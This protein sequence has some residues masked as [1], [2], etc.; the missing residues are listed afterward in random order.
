MRSCSRIATARFFGA[1]KKRHGL[2]LVELL[3]AVV[4]IGL[5][6]GIVFVKI[7]A[8]S[9]AAKRN[10]CYVNK[11]E[12]E[13]QAQL[14]F[15]NKGVWPR[16]DLSDIGSNLSYFPSGLPACPVDGTAYRFDPVTGQ[17]VGHSH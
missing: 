4:I 9:A 14:W 1:A 2:S 15:R 13:L 16:A 12:I 7:R 11:G 5:L 17:V 3:A 8:P 10:A 6:A